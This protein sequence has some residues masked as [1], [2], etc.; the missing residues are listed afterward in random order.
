VDISTLANV[1][2]AL[3]VFSGVV[4]GLLE[5]RRA[6][7][8]R[9]ERAAFAAVQAL[10]TPAWV[11]S[12]VI[13]RGIPDGASASDIEA[14]PRVLEAAQAISFILEGIGYS[15]FARLVPLKVVDDLVG[16][17][18]RVGWR[19]LRKYIDFE[20]ERAGSQKSWEWFEWLVE[21]MDRHNTTRTGL[22][23]GAP[24][25]YRDWKP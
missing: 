11:K 14:D 6:R 19:K 20:R 23:A 3:T 17:T 18:A 13:V 7:R 2:T 15:V 8:D 21:Q 1:A 12:A 16:G 25:V 22:T 10:M 24:S 5:A 4:F 9:E